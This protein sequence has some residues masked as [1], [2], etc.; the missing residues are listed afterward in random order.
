MPTIKKYSGTLKV[1]KMKKLKPLD[2]KPIPRVPS[3]ME[4]REKSLKRKVRKASIHGSYVDSRR[5]A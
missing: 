4:R 1:P 3:P 2:K 5:G